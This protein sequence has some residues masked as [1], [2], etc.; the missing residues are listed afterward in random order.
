MRLRW[1]ASGRATLLS[2]LRRIRDDNPAV[3]NDLARRIDVAVQRL[4]AFPHSGR[5]GTVPIT[6]E[7]V[8]PGLPFIV[9]YRVTDAEVQIL[10]VFHDKR[11]R[12]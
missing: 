4:E 8:I 10:R 3:A 5:I 1:I 2:S 6:R 7:L 9:V 12:L 11:E